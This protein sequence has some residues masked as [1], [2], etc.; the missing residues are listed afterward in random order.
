VE[1]HDDCRYFLFKQEA[2]GKVTLTK[3]LL[4]LD[5]TC[6]PFF[7]R[8]ESLTQVKNRGSILLALLECCRLDPELS[9]CLE[10]LTNLYHLFLLAPT[11]FDIYKKIIVVVD[12]KGAKGTVPNSR[13]AKRNFVPPA[14]CVFQLMALVAPP[15]KLRSVTALDP[16]TLELFACYFSGGHRFALL[17]RPYAELVKNLLYSQP[18]EDVT[19]DRVNTL[20]VGAEV[21][22]LFDQPAEERE[23]SRTSKLAAKNPGA[24]EIASANSAPVRAAPAATLTSPT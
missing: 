8:P 6:S 13:A 16:E 15:A 17:T 2:A 10:P 23:K 12:F 4:N 9:W 22:R 5:H 24:P 20:K 19:R 18:N 21:P 14:R 7:G 1:N 11:L 3:S